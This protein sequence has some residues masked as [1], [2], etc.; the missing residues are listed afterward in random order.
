MES[1]KNTTLRE[2][3]Q[4]SHNLL[5]GEDGFGCILPRKGQNKGVDAVEPAPSK[6]PPKTCIGMF[7]SVHNN[8]NPKT[9]RSSDFCGSFELNVYFGNVENKKSLELQFFR[10]SGAAE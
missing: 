3:T 5:N 2:I 8:K 6:A 9:R 7:E 1:V 4:L 10:Y